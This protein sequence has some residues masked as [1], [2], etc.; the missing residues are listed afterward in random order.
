MRNALRYG[1]QRAIDI[2]MMVKVIYGAS[3]AYFHKCR[4]LMAYVS[5]FVEFNG[6]FTSWLPSCQHG[7][8]TF[9]SLITT[10]YVWW[11]F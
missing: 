2:V 10:V 6:C 1:K 7:L 3:W 9:H 8:P 4:N 11:V 5:I